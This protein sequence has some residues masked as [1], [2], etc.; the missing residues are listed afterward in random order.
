MSGRRRLLDA[1]LDGFDPCPAFAAPPVAGPFDRRIA[2]QA[3]VP[4]GSTWA[5]TGVT[6]SHTKQAG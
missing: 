6:W 5:Q 2:C 3:I 1:R 4:F